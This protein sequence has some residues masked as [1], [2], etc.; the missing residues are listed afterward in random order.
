M[1]SIEQQTSPE[2]VASDAN[3]SDSSPPRINAGKSALAVEGLDGDAENTS[4]ADKLLEAEM[5][6]L[7][8]EDKAEDFDEIEKGW[9]KKSAEFHAQEKASQ[10]K[11]YTLLQ[12][13]PQTDAEWTA[14]CKKVFGSRCLELRTRD[15]CFTR[16][17]KPD[18]PVGTDQELFAWLQ[19]TENRML[20]GARAYNWV[21]P[22]LDE[23]YEKRILD[24]VVP[25]GV[26]YDYAVIMARHKSTSS[27]SLPPSKTASPKGPV[28]SA[29]GKT[30]EQLREEIKEKLK[31]ELDAN[32]KAKEADAAT[33]DWS[34]YTCRLTA[35]GSRYVNSVTRAENIEL[36]SKREDNNARIANYA[37]LGNTAYVKAR[38]GNFSKPAHGSVH[39]NW[40]S[41]FWISDTNG[42]NDLLRLYKLP[43]L[44]PNDCID[45]EFP[46]EAVTHYELSYPLLVFAVSNQYL[47]DIPW[48]SKLLN[49]EYF[50]QISKET[51]VSDYIVVVDL[52]AGSLLRAWPA[53]GS[54]K[55]L[56]LS[57][58]QT[59]V[60]EEK[61][62]LD[63][64]KVIWNISTSDDKNGAT[65]EDFLTPRTPETDIQA[66]YLWR[67]AKDE[68]ELKTKKNFSF[69]SRPD[70]PPRLIRRSI[71][72]H[73][74]QLSENNISVKVLGTELF[75]KTEYYYGRDYPV[76]DRAIFLNSCYTLMTNG[77]FQF[78]CVRAAEPSEALRCV[79]QFALKDLVDYGESPQKVYPPS[80]RMFYKAIWTSVTHV[81]V[82]YPD[83]TLVFIHS[84]SERELAIHRK[85]VAEM[86]KN[87]ENKQALKE[88]V[89]KKTFEALAEEEKANAA[90][91][92]KTSHKTE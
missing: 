66:D 47:F 14:V 34:L 1:E 58:S 25:L 44:S 55:C 88:L 35:H 83:G 18:M 43:K 71:E 38:C 69:K 20:K 23:K 31:A 89:E 36:L 75:P 59:S 74:V 77:V 29:E 24:P 17:H 70:E 37:R 51:T 78:S 92:A 62:P 60:A 72:G 52:Q 86:R 82:Q 42:K 54:V 8:V 4:D 6:L 39:G 22:L 68:L 61:E 87:M 76:T 19:T 57:T 53:E 84:M 63:Q 5:E 26:G 40:V 48:V 67:P 9:I 33:V 56:S 16:D 41:L 90:I 79:S 2:R 73:T 46:A 32:K 10:D 12:S 64:V 80:S 13:R 30:E 81:V 21:D 91:A 11:R 50:T 49:A 65:L 27:S 3:L 28:F 85:Q 15:F 7:S 45:L